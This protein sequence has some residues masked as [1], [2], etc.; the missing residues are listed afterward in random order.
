MEIQEILREKGYYSGNI[1]GEINNETINAIKIVNLINNTEIS[2]EET[3]EICYE[4]E[5][6]V[7]SHQQI[8][9]HV[10][11]MLKIQ[12]ILMGTMP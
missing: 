2:I 12:H 10:L 6:I 8:V 11:F 1:V 9:W 7:P 5:Q 4:I 3:T